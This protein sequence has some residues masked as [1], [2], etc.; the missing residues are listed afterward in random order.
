MEIYTPLSLALPEGVWPSDL[1]QSEDG[2]FLD[3]IAC[4]AYEDRGSEN[5]FSVFFRAKVLAETRIGL[6]F[7]DG[8]S[9][10]LGVGDGDDTGIVDI[11]IGG[12]FHDDAPPDIEV[13]IRTSVLSLS[14]SNSI[15]SPVTVVEENGAIKV[16]KQEG[17]IAV[18]LLFDLRLSYINDAWSFD[19]DVPAGESTGVNLPLCMIGDT[20]IL[21]EVTNLIF[22]FSGNAARP[23]G[24]D[25][26]WK[27]L[28]IG[29][30]KLYL[31]MLFQ[32]YIDI[33][34]FGIGAGGCYGS[35]AANFPLSYAEGV[36]P[37]FSG[38]LSGSLFGMEG[39]IESISLSLVQNIP[40]AA[41]IKG[42]MLLPFFDKPL[43]VTIGIDAGGGFIVGLSSETGLVDLEI[44]D[45]LKLE[46]ST[47]RF[48]V[49]DGVFTTM[50]AGKLTPLI[51]G[52][53]W[54]TFDIKELS[55]DSEGHV[56]LEGGWLDLPDQYALDFYGFQFEITQIGFGQNEDGSKWVGFSGG[57]KLVDGLPAGASVEGLK[58][59]WGNGDPAISFNGVG[60]ELEVEGAVRFKGEVSYKEFKQE[61]PV[62]SETE[63]VR[64][65][66]GAIQLELTALNFQVDAVLVIGTAIKDGESY[67]FFAIYLGVELPAGIPIFNTGLGIY[68]MAGLFAIQ[69][70]PNKLPDE[71]WYGVGDGEGWYKRPEIGV[72]DLKNKWV[73]VQD[74]LA[75]G[76]GVT[77][78]TLPD[79]GFNFSGKFLLVLILPGPILMLEG[80]ANILKERSKLDEEPVF[81]AL[82]V[83]DAR[84]GNFL[85]GLDAQYKFAE[86]GEL[87]DIHGG[88]EAFFSFADPMAWHLY[89]GKNEPRESRI[90]ANIFKLFE[91]NAYV[92]LNAHELA[93]GAWV[94]YNKNWKF[95]PLKV[96]FESWLEGNAK[97]SFQPAF[98]YGDVWAH[99]KAEL[100]VYGFG[101]GLNIDARL[102]A[103]VFDPFWIKG[104]FSVGI[105]LPWPLPDFDVDI[106]LEWG[107]EKEPPAIP[108]PLKEIALEHFKV[109]SSWV[110]QLYPGRSIPNG[111]PDGHLVNWVPSLASVPVVPLDARPHITFSRSVHDSNLIG[112]NVNDPI[113]AF[114]MIGDPDKNEGPVKVKYKIDNTIL[115]K[116]TGSAFVDVAA[117]G[118]AGVDDIFGSWAPMPGANPD[119]DAGSLNNTKLW[120]WSKTPYDYSRQI[121]R[122]WDEWFE[123][124]YENY[125]CP[126]RPQPVKTC[127]NF[128]KVALD[129]IM[130]MNFTHPDNE[131]LKIHWYSPTFQAVTEL[132]EPIA[133]LHRALCF[134]VKNNSETVKTD[135][136]Y[137]WIT[138]PVAVATVQ[139]ALRS[140][141]GVEVV[142]YGVN[143]GGSSFVLPGATVVGDGGVANPRITI[144]NDGNA[145]KIVLIKPKSRFCLAQIC[146][147]EAPSV[148]D[149]QRYEEILEHLQVEM[150]RWSQE[151]KVLE[152]Y[153]IYRMKVKSSYESVAVDTEYEGDS[154][155]EKTKDFEHFIYFRTEGPPGLVQLSPPA[156][157]SSGNSG[158]NQAAALQT[159]ELY[160]RQT[161]PATVAAQGEKPVLTKPVYRAYDIGVEFNEDYVDLMYKIAGRDLGLYLF[162]NNNQ[163]VRDES[164][165]LIVLNNEWGRTEELTLQ[166]G[167]IR[168]IN[169]LNEG[170]CAALDESI[171]PKDNTLT[172]ASKGQVLNPDTVYQARL[173]P[174]LFQESFLKNRNY[175]QVDTEGTISGPANWS[176]ETYEDVGAQEVGVLVQRSNVHGGSDNGNDPV[177]PG[178]VYFI[179]NRS[180]LA[181][182]DQPS[183]WTD[184][185]LSVVLRSSDNDAIGI[186]FRYTITPVKACYRF[187][188]GQERGYRRLV[189]IVGGVHTIL[190][191]DKFVYEKDIDYL[192]TIEAIGASI[193]IYQ[194][195][196]RIIGLTDDAI[197]KGSV[198]LYCWAN[199]NA[200]FKE[201]RI[202]D[203][204]QVAPVV[205]KFD[206]VSGLFA[207]FY[208]QVHSY[209]NE[210]WGQPVEAAVDL[211]GYSTSASDLLNDP[212]EDEYRLYDTLS[213]EILGPAAGQNPA[214]WQVSHLLQGD[215]AKGWLIRNPEPLLW[216]R[217][218]ISL[219]KATS[220]IDNTGIPGWL[221]LTGVQFS[222][223]QPNDEYIDVLL[224]EKQDIS[225]CALQTPAFDGALGVLPDIVL[226]E[227]D[228]NYKAGVLFY[229]QFGPNALDKYTIIDQGNNSRP[230]LWE[231]TGNTIVQKRNI[232]G[233]T[234]VTP[235]EA[236]GT[237]AITGDADW[238]NIQ[239]TVQLRSTDNDAI[240]V[241]FCFRDENNYYRFS[242]DNER[243]F[244]RLIKMV[245]N[246]AT[247]LWED[248]QIYT[249]NT[250]YKLV[251]QQFNGQLTGYLNEQLLFMISD[252]Q[253][254]RG[255]T[256]LYSWRNTGAVF[257]KI[258]VDSLAV[259][260]VL[261]DSAT[262]VDFVSIADAEGAIEGPSE[263]VI[264]NGAIIQRSNIRRTGNTLQALGTFAMLT[265]D[266]WED[267]AIY[268]RM[269]SQDDDEVGIMFKVDAGDPASVDPDH[270]Y[271][272]FSMNRATGKRRLIKKKED[273]YTLLWQDSFS[274]AIGQSYNIAIKTI[275]ERITIYFEEQLLLDITDSDIK[276]GGFALY[277][278]SNVNAVFERVV[279]TGN[280]YSVGQWKIKDEGTVGG[281]SAWSAMNGELRQ[282]APIHSTA[283]PAALGTYLTLPPQNWQSYAVTARLKVEREGAIGIMFRYQDEHNYYRFSMDSQRSYRRI[284]KVKNGVAVALDTNASPFE[285]GHFTDIKIEAIRD[286]LSVVMDDELILEATDND[287]STG[288]IALYNSWSNGAVYS[289]LQVKMP[290]MEAYT[291]FRDSF[292]DDDI[293]AWQV[294]DVG[295]S[296]PSHWQTE[297]G[298]VRQTS[299]INNGEAIG[300]I[301]KKGTMLITGKASWDN[302]IL[303]ASISSSDNDEIG[304]V[305]R[306][307]DNNNYYRFTMNR[308][309]KYRRLTLVH[310]AVSAILWQ[311]TFV[312]TQN[313]FYHIAIA[314]MQDR[315]YVHT[316]DMLTLAVKDNTIVSGKAG[317]FCWA[318]AGSLYS[319]VRVYSAELIQD[320]YLLHEQFAIE[321]KVD[322]SIIDEGKV[323]APSAWSFELNK[324]VQQSDIRS[325]DSDRLIPSKAG[326]Y[327]LHDKI[328]IQDIRINVVFD[329]DDDDAAGVIFGYIDATHY[330][331]FSMDRQRKYRRLVQR[332]GMEYLVLWE[333]LAVGYD[334]SF[335]NT[336]TIDHAAGMIVGYLNGIR[337][338]TYADGG[339]QRGGKIGLYCWGNR[340][341]Y[342]HEVTVQA[343][344]WHTL[345]RFDK[346][347]RV[348]DGTHF[349]IH[350]G[351]A[352]DM[353]QEEPTIRRR[354]M[355]RFGETGDIHFR[356]TRQQLRII[357]RNGNSIHDQQFLQ[358]DQYAAFAARIIRKRD[359]TGFFLFPSVA[360]ELKTNTYRL[361]L[362]FR[363]NNTTDVPD[364]QVWRQAGDDL[365]EVVFIHI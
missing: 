269:H 75:L 355:A 114:E 130:P 95:G 258:R 132:E 315:I 152:P 136:N 115:Q 209:N 52:L 268:V 219:Q 202:D 107:P 133:N 141:H 328:F 197:E 79:N 160:V 282:D 59:T 192:I 256:G 298:M 278:Y 325:E 354:Y 62:T 264:E 338:F 84:E 190:Y 153:S 33:T 83:L 332:K 243:Q 16:E 227:D 118:I 302:I 174:L 205:Y 232:Y 356:N 242:M 286:Q 110:P 165:K 17:V 365:E 185:R 318:N 126:P 64:R 206:F 105:G 50:I 26:G 196:T 85:F 273:D 177:K 45:V 71:P 255:K 128:E 54:P 4:I 157:T 188:M 289:R 199:T 236:P 29:E 140:E 122:S 139:L 142:A 28:Y 259:S 91:A 235:L 68:G 228:F 244:R 358:Q 307:Q 37:P 46:I 246:V 323:G 70:E 120:L 301:D 220:K 92:M 116:L 151:G 169:Q 216:E 66:D 337:L 252:T 310:G 215:E 313:E 2:N 176:W 272:R 266:T 211:A 81:R 207:N 362:K 203:Y 201:V 22:N 18:P 113:P 186:V 51:A 147:W 12:A 221:K 285:A 163:P 349:R 94:G 231:V 208:H 164:G 226:F 158:N 77:I 277:A 233:G 317:L 67:N 19:L 218:E 324:L 305:F 329:A 5:G 360:E 14:F 134:P 129:E 280:S 238:E 97:L 98:F 9:L 198:G 260:P 89:I 191:E 32:G 145:I 181:A 361:E 321:S 347:E 330:Y 143:E 263:W 225:Y 195:G 78:G 109:S 112:V 172:T 295:T 276:K 292:P 3:N 224:R 156:D 352:A 100:A 237:M 73:N 229:E 359:G 72:T 241:V 96:I 250:A 210:L 31:P 182:P 20:G 125:P 146:V 154:D 293:S 290:A 87:I 162:D 254:S 175:W 334:E 63:T 57:L 159:L 35:I 76:A 300:S 171:I 69:M 93:M 38:P 27:G 288:G 102:A 60:V 166:E 345:Y 86:G 344:A 248:Q 150:A 155:F 124:I 48:E 304:L 90:R 21:I 299:N 7:L 200:Q 127:Y 137:V 25:V 212:T 222:T 343:A 309:A 279:V 179:K 257:E 138:L 247:I 101:L 223:T 39:G 178:T 11:S 239:L 341:T 283:F 131:G 230:S 121:D 34:D 339:V 213:N 108:E 303:R 320:N 65:F 265:S 336:I 287:F 15:L 189:R 306:Y 314:A 353:A 80:K 117:K 363:K 180:E 170:S 271:Y 217:M 251:I 312:Y 261:Y 82:A 30:G 262:A 119:P 88:T 214:E 161:I 106:T 234:V 103:Q 284:T 335:T 364:S 99:G 253:F 194:D 346:E 322:W 74:S 327:A 331:R 245:G 187:S 267:A 173:L 10:V 326:T 24:T 148:E 111:A 44:S 333:D 270:N 249:V 47:I 297:N 296:S 41:A 13:W 193:K 36:T 1:F 53:D 281:P 357:D 308:Q 294:K 342:F 6:P 204:R 23:A 183:N 55:I 8:I 40:T 274:Y 123:D 351:N 291:L 42:Q 319:N 348:A 316:N 167:E 49:E 144:E 61:N 340:N 56:K 311:D 135:S 240:G 184:Y 104:E 350:A 275:G 58:I 149:T 168:Y 43:D